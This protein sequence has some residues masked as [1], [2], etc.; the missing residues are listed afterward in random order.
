[1]RISGDNQKI[2]SYVIRFGPEETL[3]KKSNCETPL[4]YTGIMI[5]NQMRR[6]RISV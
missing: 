2:E 5:N 4:F 3:R 6:E 1:M